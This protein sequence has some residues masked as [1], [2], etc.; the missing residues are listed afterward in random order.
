MRS[1]LNVCHKMAHRTELHAGQ[2]TQSNAL[3][4]KHH[5]VTGGQSI[6][7]YPI[8]VEHTE[9]LDSFGEIQL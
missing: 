8:I 5:H 2:V 9:A 7:A 3:H 6:D 4:I 1:Y